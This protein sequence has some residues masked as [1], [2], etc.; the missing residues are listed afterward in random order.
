MNIKDFIKENKITTDNDLL[1]WMKSNIRYCDFTTL[2]SAEDVIKSGCGSCHDQ[3]NLEYQ[4]LKHLGYK[5][6][7]LFFI[8]YN[9]NSNEG[10]MT[11]SLCYYEKDGYICWFENSWGGNE[12]IRKYDTIKDL[13]DDCL[14]RYNKLKISK[15]PYLKFKNIKISIFKPGSSLGDFVDSIY[16]EGTIFTDIEFI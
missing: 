8:S 2:K 9:K 6:C 11:H 1:K 7:I 3:V 13:K 4:C 15:F 10:G 16:N 14:D 12:G 5:P